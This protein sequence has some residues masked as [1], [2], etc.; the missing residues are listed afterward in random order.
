MALALRGLKGRFILSLNA[1]SEVKG[2]FKG[3]SIEEVE[4]TY[5]IAKGAGKRVTEVLISGRR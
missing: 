2:I 4:T 3:F 5:S 1:V